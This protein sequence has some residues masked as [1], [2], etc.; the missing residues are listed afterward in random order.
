MG[1]DQA[2]ETENG[3]TIEMESGHTI[4]VINIQPYEITTDR[5]VQVN[6]I[7]FNPKAPIDSVKHLTYKVHL[8][9]EKIE[10][11][12]KQ[13]RVL[14]RAVERLRIAKSKLKLRNIEIKK[15]E[16][17]KEKTKVKEKTKENVTKILPVSMTMLF[18]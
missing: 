15:E 14:K 10:E 18:N 7:S 16:R 13:I 4:E 12:N 1:S 9:R 2:T 5:A 8:Y 6:T 17:A 3:N 11:K